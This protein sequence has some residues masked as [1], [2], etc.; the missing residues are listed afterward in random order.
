MC[1][2]KNVEYLV[3]NKLEPQLY[4][5]FLLLCNCLGSLILTEL[6]LG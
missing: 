3:L 1:N 5:E 2:V 6:L 4:N